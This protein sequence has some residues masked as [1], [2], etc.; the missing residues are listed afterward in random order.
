[1]WISIPFPL[2][3]MVVLIALVS[4]FIVTPGA[5]AV[6][7]FV[8]HQHL[9]VFVL[10]WSTTNCLIT[11]PLNDLCVVWL[12]PM[13]LNKIIAP[14]LRMV[15][16]AFATICGVTIMVMLYIVRWRGICCFVSNKIFS[17]YL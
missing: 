2:M 6:V 15:G 3:R 17:D 10:L 7:L 16:G 8:I 14:F 5:I 4:A 1:M 11:W 12:E 9:L 13:A